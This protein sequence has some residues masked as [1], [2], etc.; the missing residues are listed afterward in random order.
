MTKDELQ[1]QLSSII[2]ALPYHSSVNRISLFGSRLHGNA[3]KDSDVD[4]LLEL[5]KPMSMLKVINLERRLSEAL[6]IKVDLCTPMSLSKYFR[7]DVLKEAE[8]L[9]TSVP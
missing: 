9:Y 3:R 2:K 4:L 8:P 6:G 5:K 1:K 7:S